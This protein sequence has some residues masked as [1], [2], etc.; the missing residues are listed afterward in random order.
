[1]GLSN[2]EFRSRQCVKYTIIA[3]WQNIFSSKMFQ[4]HVEMMRS[5]IY[6]V[7]SQLA[8]TRKYPN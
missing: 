2:C 3:K 7:I 8:S 1:M 6:I 4:K 5:K